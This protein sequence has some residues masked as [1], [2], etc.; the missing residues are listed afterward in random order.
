M[1]KFITIILIISLVMTLGLAGC[2]NEAP[3]EPVEDPSGENEPEEEQENEGTSGNDEVEYGGVLKIAGESEPGNLNSIIWPTTSDTNVT[4]MIY[5]SLV[6]PDE[7]LEMVG[8]LAESWDITED[9]KTYTFY[10]HE[11][12]K[13]HDG[14]PFTSDDVA[15][16]LRSMAHPE[17][18]AG[19]T[20]RVTPIL[21]AEA[22]RNG[23]ADSIEGIEI[24]DEYTIKITTEEPYAPFLASLFIG[25]LPEH[26]LGEISP[27][28][29]AKHD[30]NRAPIGTGPFKFKEWETGQYIELE[31]N[32][33]Y[34]K[35]EP[36]LDGLIYRFGDVNTMLAAFMNN[37]VDIAPIPVAEV[38]SV[39]S[40]D[41]AEIKLQSMLS[42]YYIGFNLRNEFF[43]ELEVRQAL[44]YGMNKDLIV[45]SV[46]G[47]Y[48]KV[49]HDA[50]PSN[51]WSH[52]PNITEYNYNPEKAEELLQDAGFEKNNDGYYERDGKVL[53]FTLEVPTGKQERERTAVLLKQDWEE[54]GVKVELQQLDFP[55]LVTKLLPQ[56]KDGKQREV[57]AEDFDAYILGFGVEA[58]P[59]EY[60]PY[61][62]SAF[63]PPNGYNFCGYSDPEMDE[64]LNEQY[65]EVDQ[66]ARQEI[67]WEI[68]ER[69]SEEQPWI[70]IYSQ[71][72]LFVANDKVKDF[73][74]DFRGVTF[75]AEEWYLEQ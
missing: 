1:K 39:S 25:V 68:G 10:L 50:F 34:F 57:E 38:E 75:K 9:G 22:Y 47:E 11:N 48:G 40:L 52:S 61:F 17:Y 72:S 27:A 58:D 71:Y 36:K 30:T 67:F 31:A 66:E 62:H 33:E 12:V 3:E 13:W 29:W 65:K 56:T 24:I 20:S 49:E 45:Q 41:F 60:R 73:A 53:G 69:L 35:G 54:I 19:S 70:P 37:E 59:D 14:E 63:M 5:N 26:I 43:D 23:E 32:D 6:I 44:A 8:D 4:H 16:T 74:P 28:E 2:T 21:G 15:F 18:D 51:H 7:E 55:T 42:V 64:M 46:L